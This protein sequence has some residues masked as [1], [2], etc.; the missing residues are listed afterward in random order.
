MLVDLI[1]CSTGRLVK[2]HVVCSLSK[3]IDL[4]V[5]KAEDRKDRGA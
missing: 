2:Y 3:G 5:S 4:E 1:N